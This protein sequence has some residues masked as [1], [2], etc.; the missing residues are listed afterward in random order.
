VLQTRFESLRGIVELTDFMPIG[1]D[2]SHVVRIVTGV[3]GCV[4]LKSNL[5]VRFDYGLSVPWTT[6][7]DS[8]TIIMIAGPDCLALRSDTE[9]EIDKGRVVSRFKVKKGDRITFVL[10][11]GPSYLP[12][13]STLEPERL[14]QK[15]KAYWKGWSGR[16]KSAGRWTE[17]VRRSL[18]T[19]KGLTYAPTGGIVAAVTASL[20]ERIGGDRNWDYRYCWLR[21]ATVTLLALLRAGYEE[22]AEE[23]RAWLFRAAA[24]DPEQIQIMYGVAGEKRLKEWTLPWLPGFEHSRPVRV[25]NDAAS[26]VQLDIYGELFHTLSIAVE[27]GLIPFPRGPDFGTKLLDLLEQ[28]WSTPD[29]GMW[30]IRGDPQHFTHSKVMAWVAFDRAA[31]NRRFGV[32]RAS[33]R[34]YRRIADHIH[35]NICE[36]A[37][38]PHQNC[39][40]QSYGRPHLD[41]SLLLMPLVGFL[42]A[43]DERMRNTVSQIELRLLVDGLV[44]RYETGS[45]VD[46]LSDGEGVFLA[47]S[48]WLVD[49]Y[50]L[51]GRLEEAESLFERL[52]SIGNDVGLFAEEY[53]PRE[54]RQLGNFP[55]AFTHVALVGSAFKLVHAF[56]EIA[57]KTG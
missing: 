22:E 20:P 16:C 9:P 43:D 1:L 42:P 18:I 17:I 7:A 28:K 34:R 19:L 36:N 10:S 41:A 13:P 52:V 30:E 29:A 11:H 46:G 45:G 26:Q 55:Q 5:I 8:K 2:G 6:E 49:N 12:P 21:D 50:I 3:E 27:G 23:W 51:Q 37:I 40:V 33:Q 38:D 56:E 47:C 57:I 4:P 24:G 25:G 54:R 44:L 48:F 15:T 31:N 35:E 39:F 32:D 53:D 14:L